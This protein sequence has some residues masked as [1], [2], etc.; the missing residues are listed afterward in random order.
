MFC[1]VGF[2]EIKIL[3]CYFKYDKSY[4]SFYFDF[5]NKTI[6]KKASEEHEE[7]YTSP[8]IFD[9]NG[10]Y[11]YYIG[12]AKDDRNDYNVRF[13]SLSTNFDNHLEIIS[14]YGNKF[15][16]RRITGEFDKI[17]PIVYPTYEELTDGDWITGYRKSVF[18]SESD[19]FEVERKKYEIIR[20][21][22]R[23]GRVTFP[24]RDKYICDGL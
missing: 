18:I 13:W 11:S 6:E 9:E 17:S 3:S 8:I 5:K 4:T 2:A 20:E 12:T 19:S 15:D 1:N 16:Y 22:I 24:R 21:F 14:G 7:K 10:A 23:F